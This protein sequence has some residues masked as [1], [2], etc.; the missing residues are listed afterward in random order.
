MIIIVWFV[1]HICIN[2]AIPLKLSLKEGHVRLLVSVETYWLL[3]LLN[4]ARRGFGSRTHN[5]DRKTATNELIRTQD[6]SSRQAQTENWQKPKLHFPLRDQSSHGAVALR[7]WH[8]PSFHGAMIGF[9]ALESRTP[10]LDQSRLRAN[11][12]G[13]RPGPALPCLG[14]FSDS[15]PI[16][17]TSTDVFLAPSNEAGFGPLELK[18][19]WHICKN[20]YRQANR[21]WQGM[22]QG[23]AGWCYGRLSFSWN[24]KLHASVTWLFTKDEERENI[25]F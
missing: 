1:V 4:R 20:V 14:F 17:L 9:V 2:S 3:W 24:H 5:T 21:T 12:G 19:R 15:R 18:A 25:F 22:E 6:S 10:D 16:E 7:A 11:P 13:S 8:R 23:G